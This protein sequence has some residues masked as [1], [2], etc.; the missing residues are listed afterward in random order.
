MFAGK[1]GFSMGFPPG[2]RGSAKHAKGLVSVPWKPEQEETGLKAGRE[3]IT[4]TKA[5]SKCQG[6]DTS[7]GCREGWK[8]AT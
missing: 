5:N 6:C 8:K 7:G 4:G 1:K 2:Q 3:I